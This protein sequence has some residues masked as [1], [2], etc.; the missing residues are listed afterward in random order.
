M[1]S[2]GQPVMP[3]ARMD[4]TTTSQE[5]AAA[6]EQAPRTRPKSTDAR[7]SVKKL[8]AGV[9]HP[10]APPHSDLADKLHQKRA[11]QLAAMEGTALM[12]FRQPQQ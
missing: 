12:P 1:T 8:P 4:T 10:N 9:Q 5:A 11:S 2:P 6:V 3:D 7:Q